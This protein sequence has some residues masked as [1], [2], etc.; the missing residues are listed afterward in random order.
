M[1]RCCVLLRA[2]CARIRDT[3]RVLVV[4]WLSVW[5]IQRYLWHSGLQFVLNAERW[6]MI[7][8]SSY[9]TRV[10]YPAPS[11]CFTDA[12]KYDT[13]EGLP[14]NLQVGGSSSTGI[15]GNFC[16]SVSACILI[17]S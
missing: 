11:L 13:N 8:S 15:I 7:L 2:V 6:N 12:I 17:Q 1:H 9:G 4:G 16:L 14:V 5:D 10:V 3:G